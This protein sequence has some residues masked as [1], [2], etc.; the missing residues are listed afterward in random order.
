MDENHKNL[1]NDERELND[2]KEN[3]STIR[4]KWSTKKAYLE[5]ESAQSKDIKSLEA[6]IKNIMNHKID[7]A[8]LKD[9]I[10]YKDIKLDIGLF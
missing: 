9:K 1:R 10:G 6:C 8:K 3:L 7:L 2:A 4:S 5:Q